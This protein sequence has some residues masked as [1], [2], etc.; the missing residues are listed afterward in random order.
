M[1]NLE[2]KPVVIH[3]EEERCAREKIDGKKCSSVDIKVYIMHKGERLPICEKCSDELA[4][5][6]WETKE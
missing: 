2:E 3:V 1:K 4:D 6:M 5:S